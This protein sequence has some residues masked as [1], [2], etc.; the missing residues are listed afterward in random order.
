MIVLH[1]NSLYKQINMKFLYETFFF[2]DFVWIPEEKKVIFKYSLDEK[3]SFQETFVFDFEWTKKIPKSMLEKALL[4]L[5]IMAGI[6]YFKTYLPPKIKIK[7]FSLTRSQA[8]FF[9]KTYTLGLGEFWYQNNINPKDKINFP[10]HSSLPQTSSEKTSFQGNLVLIG[11]GK[12]SITTA[13]IL[14]SQNEDFETLTIGNYVFFDTMLKKIDKTHLT[15]HRKLDLKLKEINAQGAFNGHVPISA[16]LAFTSIIVAILRGRK[17][18]ILSN[19]SSAN[20]ENTKAFGININHQYSKSLEFEQDFQNYVRE[21]ISSDINYFSFLRPLSELKI[22]E[23]FCKNWFKKYQK[24]FASCNKNFVISNKNKKFSWC[25]Q[26]PKCAF[27]FLLFSPFLTRQEVN[28]IFEKDL[29]KDKNLKKT[30]QELAGIK[31]QKPFECV[32]EVSEIQEAIRLALKKSDWNDLKPLQMKNPPS[33]NHKFSLHS[34]PKK[35]EKIL[36]NFL[37][38]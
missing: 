15:I 10:Y 26:C 24:H 21:N 4:G 30:F 14:K 19:E 8:Q 27:V 32:G 12:D 6:S 13:E 1:T 5:W 34:M 2:E 17:N 20:N 23:V 35:F 11:G 25:G 29:L 18:T 37:T 38:K 31:G 28:N 16:I 9:T 36:A 7:K 3:I 33:H 22:A